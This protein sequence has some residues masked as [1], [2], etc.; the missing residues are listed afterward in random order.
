MKRLALS[1][2]LATFAVLAVA[3]TASA[4]TELLAGDPADGAVLHQAPTS[5]TL[6]FSEPVPAESATIT[7]AAPD[8]TQWQT[9]EISASG[10]TLTAVVTPKGTPPGLYTLTWQVVA[11]DGDYV[12]GKT[13]FTLSPA[14][15]PTPAP[16]PTSAPAPAPAPATSLPAPPTGEGPTTGQSVITVSAFASSRPTATA[17]TPEQDSGVPIWAWVVGALILAALAV[18]VALRL[19]D[20]KEQQER[21]D[22]GT[23]DPP[24]A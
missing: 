18:A 7:V 11:L 12:D 22:D 1:A 3:P 20:R 15:T 13:T 8:N 17:P 21:E 16:I 4:H 24:S 23:P 14:A 5:L 10:S 19:K 2:L 9:G 6:T